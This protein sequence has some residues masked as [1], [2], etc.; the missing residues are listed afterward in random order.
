[1]LA[2]PCRAETTTA[3]WLFET[4]MHC[5][6]LAV[7]VRHNVSSDIEEAFPIIII[8]SSGFQLP[9]RYLLCGN[10]LK[11]GVADLNKCLQNNGESCHR[12]G[13]DNSR[14]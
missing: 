9:G 8:V 3:A 12:P 2:V 6:M 11:M 4:I 7:H 14:R 1:M 13:V 5:D 10:Y